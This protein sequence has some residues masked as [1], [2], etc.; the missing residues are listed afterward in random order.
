MNDEQVRRRLM[1]TL[2]AAVRLGR[3]GALPDNVVAAEL[4]DLADL[5][6]AAA[7][8]VAREAQRVAY[9]D[10]GRGPEGVVLP[11]S[12]WPIQDLR[13]PVAVPTECGFELDESGD[14]ITHTH[15]C[16]KTSG[17]AD[18]PGGSDHLC[19]SCGVLYDA[20]GGT[21]APIAMAGLP[22]GGN[23]PVTEPEEIE[24]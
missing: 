13:T 6:L 2:S 8:Q 17:H 19:E 1:T 12:A 15:R 18:G 3:A 10:F 4:A 9:A 24:L 7:A 22:L 21:A 11:E 23:G 20:Q 16:Q 5:Y 14:G